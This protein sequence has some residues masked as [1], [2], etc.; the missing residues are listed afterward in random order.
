[1]HSYG[2][3]PESKPQPFVLITMYID[4]LIH[5]FFKAKILINIWNNQSTNMKYGLWINIYIYT[6]LFNWTILIPH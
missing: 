4:I 2:K 1:M 6:Y 5:M 3:L